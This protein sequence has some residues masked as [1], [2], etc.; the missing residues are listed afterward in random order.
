MPSDPYPRVGHTLVASDE[1]QEVDL[2]T[3]GRLFHWLNGRNPLLARRRFG[4]LYWI[5]WKR[6]VLSFFLTMFGFTF[7]VIGTS[8]MAVC[9]EFDRGVGFFVIGLI[10]LMPGLFGSLT[11]LFYLQGRKGY[12][13]KMLPDYD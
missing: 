10:M 5:A 7:G 3:I 4:K 13:Y 9:T 1:D 8:C 2:K 11:L 12:S 6:F